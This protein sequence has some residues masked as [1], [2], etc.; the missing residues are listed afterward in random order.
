MGANVF[1]FFP[2]FLLLESHFE[3]YLV[4]GDSTINSSPIIFPP[5]LTESGA[6]SQV[7]LP[8]C[9]CAAVRGARTAPLIIHKKY[10]PAQINGAD[11]MHA[12]AAATLDSCT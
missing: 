2:L 10:R 5:Q 1:F 12:A 9:V 6:S 7:S 3:S 11:I 4:K 8:S